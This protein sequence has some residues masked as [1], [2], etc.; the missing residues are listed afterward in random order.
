MSL[1]Y[2]IKLL[3]WFNFFTEFRLYA[4][5]AIIYFI[6]VTHSYALGGSIFSIIYIS[7][8]FLDVPA[9]LLAD[10]IGR[11]KIVVLGSTALLFAVIFYAIGMNYWFLAIGALLEGV[12]RSL[13]S[14]N[15]DALLYNLLSEEGLAHE[16]HT[17]SGKLSSM[18]EIAL[19]SSGLLGGIIA[20]WSFP[21]VM[22]LS[23]IPQ[24]ICVLLSLHI[25]DIKRIAEPKSHVWQDLSK[26]WQ[27]FLHNPQLR[28]LSYASVV[29]YATGEAV[30][31]FQS[32]FYNMLLPVWLVGIVKTLANVVA[33]IGFYL[34]GRTMRRFHEVT[35]LM[36]G[37]I[38]SRVA[39]SISLLFPTI[40]SPFLMM[41][42][43]FF[44]GLG[45]TASRSL[46]QKDFTDKQRATMSSL[47]SFAGSLVFGILTFTLGLC[48]DHI[49]LVPS[50][51]IIQIIALP[52]IW[53]TWRLYKLS[54]HELAR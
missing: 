8:A 12:S 38:Y 50:M 13:Y 28:L 2:N 36:F 23:V 16:F 37:A 43:S 52:A 41:S 26:A 31:E 47:N 21:L 32:A 46:M 20:N 54:R 30:Y 49:G 19:A 51:L 7:A 4:P 22:W 39:N 53:F 44:F 18:F 40:V 3:R 1:Q 48:A 27:G 6:H 24:I 25:K 15:N 11:K 34:S 10:R 45:T 42:T 5:I 35:V 14:G 17:Y 29:N 9:G 33:A